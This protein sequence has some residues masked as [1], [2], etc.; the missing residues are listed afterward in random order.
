MKSILLLA[1]V[2]PAAIGQ[3]GTASIVGTILDAKTLKPIPAALVMAVRAGAPPLA[4]NTKSGGDG[5]F[6]IHGVPA[7]KYLL[8]VQ[9]SGDGYLDPCQWSGTPTTVTLA[10]GQAAA[11][12]SLR[13]APA[14]LL[15][16]KC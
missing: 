13:L 16:V 9:A 15:S 8:C 4:R 2:V 12:V 6:Q 7:G 3:T 14:S 5:A 10:S 11:G 1:L